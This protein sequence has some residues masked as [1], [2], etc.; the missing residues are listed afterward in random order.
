VISGT[1]KH[2][3]RKNLLLTFTPTACRRIYNSSKL[4]KKNYFHVGQTKEK[5]N[6]PEVVFRDFYL[7]FKSGVTI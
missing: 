3:C 5:M 4:D 1:R 7:F 6:K 2:H